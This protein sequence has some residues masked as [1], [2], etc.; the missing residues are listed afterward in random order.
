MSRPDPSE[1]MVEHACA[2][3]RRLGEAEPSREAAGAA[4]EEIEA[5]WRRRPLTVGVAG[6]DAVARAELLSALCGGL[7]DPAARG[8][9]AAPVRVRRGEAARFRATLRDGTTEEAAL[10][11]GVSS[12][13]TAAPAADGD[14]RAAGD[15]DAARARVSELEVEA[16]RAERAVPRLAREVP[17]WWAIWLWLVRWLV[18]RR[19]RPQLETWQR[20]KEQLATAR[21]ALGAGEAAAA[22]AAEA[23]ASAVASQR[24]RVLERL[25]VLGSGSGAGREVAELSIE[26]TGGPLAEGVEAIELSGAAPRPAV[27]VTLQV[28]AAEVGLDAGDGDGDGARRALGRPAEAAF[29]LARLPAEA[30]ARRA[31]RRAGEVLAAEIARF[32]DTVA[33]AEADHRDRLARLEALRLPDAEGFVRGH[34]EAA[35]A[36]ATASITAVLDHASVHLGSELA[37]LAAQWASLVE[38]AGSADDLRAAATRIDEESVAESKRIAGEVKLLVTGG[39]GGSAHD[40]LRELIATLRQPGLPAELSGPPKRVP[41]L[42]PVALLPSLAEPQPTTFAAELNGVGKRIAGL[43]RSIEARRTELRDKVR[44]RSELFSAAAAAEL[45][46]A[47]PALRAALL[48]A[49]GRELTAAV[50]RRVAWVDAALVKEQAAIDAERAALQ[51]LAEALEAARRDARWLEDRL[52]GREPAAEPKA[53]A[54]P[55]AAAGASAAP[56]TASSSSSLSPSPASDG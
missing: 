28:T 49:V 34:L 42:P 22:E 36:P 40:L 53:D 52:G 31:A 16:L 47:E 14:G 27:D 55:A 7:L 44:E 5:A 19:A 6:D 54:E 2:A 51:P 38:A 25:Q 18:V 9:E 32:A 11:A 39:V 48:E 41:A 23:R 20:A 13:T 15:P 35:G 1:A 50:E 17:P 56:T 29:K 30:R 8:P 12:G 24:A 43:F 33:R 4:L 46:G 10:P 21:R 3:L 26:V 45:L 37:Q